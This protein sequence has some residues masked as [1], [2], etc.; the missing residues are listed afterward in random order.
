[1][2]FSNPTKNPD[3]TFE[4]QPVVG[5]LSTSLLFLLCTTYYISSAEEVQLIL[6]K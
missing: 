5:R 1:M 3:S 6:E 2:L 4:Y